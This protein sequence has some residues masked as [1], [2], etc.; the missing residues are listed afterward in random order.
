MNTN[1]HTTP[2]TIA[3]RAA[4]KGDF[5]F[6]ST[7]MV[8][9]LHDWYGGDH[10]A[11]AKRIFDAHMAGG[12]DHVGHFSAEQHMFILEVDGQRA[13][14]VHVVV[15]KQ[16]TA[17]M[18][19][20]IVAPEFK[21]VR[22]LGARLL[23]YAEAFA[24]GRGA[25]QIYGTVAKQNTKAFGFF[26]HMGYAVAGESIGHYKPGV[27]EVMI[28]KLL[29]SQPVDEK[30]S[31]SVVEF[32]RVRHAE[33]VKQL[34]LLKLAPLFNG[35]DEGWVE[36][37]YRGYER[38]NTREPNSKYKLVFVAID[39]GGK[40]LGVAGCTPKK[41]EPIKLMPCLGSTPAAFAALLTDIPFKLRQYGRKLYLHTVPTPDEVVVLQRLGWSLN[42]IMPAAYHPRQCTQ[43]WS[44]NL[45]NNMV[46][47]MRVK[48]ALLQ[49]I[50]AGTKT[51]EVRAGYPDIRE[52]SAG[53]SIHF[54]S[55]REECDVNVKAVRVYR[56]INSMMA[57]EDHRRMAENMT[58]REVNDLLHGIYPAGREVLGIYVLEIERSE[59]TRT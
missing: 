47:N 27:T 30:A 54:M 12:Q 36:A 7:L 14:M 59:R 26:Q 23:S 58:R 29:D 24:L 39:R 49:Q 31:I 42:A 44:N 38:R 28:Y 16:G 20:L 35:V 22:G 56:D 25:R 41:G 17:K 52:I 21:S 3:V 46:R 50:A 10:E 4:G 13:G 53:D 18:S 8:Q 2:H 19:P 32:D 11:H 55:A 1:S 48:R 37:L 33:Q 34:I 40:V 15:K 45:E 6:V 9:A 5:P 43:Q 57:V 51:L